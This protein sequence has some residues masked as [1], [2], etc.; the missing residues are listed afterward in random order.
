MTDF[1]PTPADRFAFGLWTVG[2]SGLDL[3]GERHPVPARPVEAV[4]RLAELGAYGV[5]FHDDDLVPFGSRRATRD[6]IIARFREALAPTGVVAS[7]VTT[8]LFSH[9]IFKDGGFTSNDRAVRRFAIKKVL[10]NIDLAAEL[11]APDLRALGR[12]GGRRVRRGQGRRGSPRPVP[13]GHEHPLRVRARARLR[14]SLRPRTQAQRAPRRHP[15]ADDRPRARLHQLPG[16]LRDS[17]AST[18]RSGT[19]RWPDST[20]PRASPRRCGTANCSTST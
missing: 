11:G 12:P 6:K 18:P 16:R 7:M 14:H 1:T 15:A 8:N 4:H 10:R 17:S 5:S 19:R 3:F 2:W 20:S 13:R 9:P